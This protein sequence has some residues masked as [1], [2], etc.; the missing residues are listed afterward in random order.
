[1]IRDIK[2][3][4]LPIDRNTNLYAGKTLVTSKDLYGGGEVRM[5]AM[6]VLIVAET[7]EPW[8]R[9]VRCKVVPGQEGELDYPINSESWPHG[10]L[11]SYDELA[12]L[13]DIDADIFYELDNIESDV[14]FA[15][16]DLFKSDYDSVRGYHG[17]ME[18]ALQIISEALDK[19]SC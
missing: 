4:L 11:F 10:S 6:T 19:L 14:R 16:M 5:P 2:S 17:S 18:K 8:D 15:K 9:Y 7:P 12:E 13:S 3:E 1:M